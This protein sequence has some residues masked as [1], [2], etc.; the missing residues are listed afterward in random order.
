MRAGNRKFR[1]AAVNYVQQINAVAPMMTLRPECGVCQDMTSLRA[2]TCR[3]R[4]RGYWWNLD[5]RRPRME[6]VS[7]GCARLYRTAI[8]E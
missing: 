7:Y 5:T 6:L 4:P 3:N 2:I 1:Q 8:I